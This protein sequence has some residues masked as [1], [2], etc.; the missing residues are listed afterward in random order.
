[1]SS[2]RRRSAMLSNRLGA[3]H[4][5]QCPESAHLA[6]CRTTWRRS[7]NRAHSRHSASAAGTALYAQTCR[8]LKPTIRVRDDVKRTFEDAAAGS[9]VDPRRTS[10]SLLA[11]SHFVAPVPPIP[12][13]T[14]GMMDTALKP[15]A[16]PIWPPAANSFV[17]ELSFTAAGG[18]SQCTQ[19]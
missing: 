10:R 5:R 2:S 14:P 6:R 15:G 16:C 3:R 9:V 12:V 18:L 11:R 17:F 19:N 8:S 4:L 13:K 1:M 7:P